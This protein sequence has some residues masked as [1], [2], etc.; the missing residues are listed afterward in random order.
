MTMLDTELRTYLSIA[1]EA[2][3]SAG[4]FLSKRGPSS[5]KVNFSDGKDIKLAADIDSENIIFEHL[6]ENSQFSILSEEKGL[7]VRGEQEPMWI[8]DP[9]DGTMNY[10][11]NIPICCVSIGLWHKDQPLLG[12]VYDF[13]TEEFYTGI[14]GEGAWIGEEQINAS[15]V[16]Q[17][18]GAILGT[19]FPSKTD[20]S[21]ESLN[22]MIA[23][24]QD[25]K[26]IRM[27]GSA[28]MAIC[29]VA[30]GKTEAYRE[31]D[32]MLWDIGGGVPIIL[33]A[34]GKAVYTPKGSE[35]AH[36]VFISNGKI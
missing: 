2:A 7:V 15:D 19:G 18:Q 33:A 3:L 29:Y 5:A 17:K 1:K 34:G 10:Y 24:I 16:D 11:R 14:V 32:I 12:V 13:N 30:C 31:N 36:D 22:T 35:Y 8:V 25:Y 28:A 27:I 9:L 6:E 4:K 23:D 21:E 20:L 26:K